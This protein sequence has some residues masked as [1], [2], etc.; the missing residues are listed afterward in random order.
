MSC[1]ILFSRP[2]ASVSLKCFRFYPS[3]PTRRRCAPG[4]HQRSL[5]TPPTPTESV[6]VGPL[7]STFRR[8][9]IFSLSSLTL[10]CTLTPFMFLM[11]SNLPTTARLALA[12]IAV[13]TSGISTG[14]VGWCGKPYVAKFRRLVSEKNGGV[15]GIEMSTF[16]LLLRTRI[17]RVSD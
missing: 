7:A 14:L 9:K 1:C 3:F 5:S 10:S 6:Y 12:S 13:G 11:E 16:D 15:Q 8:L 17:T 2:P 4:L